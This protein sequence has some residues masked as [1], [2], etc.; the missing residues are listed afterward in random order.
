MNLLSISNLSKIG[1]EEPLFTGV[2]FG[3][4]EG[5]KA[6]L[7]GKNGTGKSTLLNTIAGVL[8]PDEGSIVLNKAGGVSFL[9][10]NPLYQNDDTIREHIFKSDSPKLK[11]INEYQELC[12][13]LGSLNQTQQN[14]YDELM[15][16][17]ESQDL[18]NYES[19]ISSILNTLGITDMSRKMGSLSGGM[20][21]KVAL[22]QVLVEDTKLLLLDEPTNHLDITT[23]KWLQ[24]YLKQTGRALLM[25]THDRYFLDNV[26]TNIYELDHHRLKLYQG[27]YSTYL[28][29]KQTEN[30]IAQ[31]TDRRIESVLRIERDWLM[32]GPCARGTK[33]KARIQRDMELINREKFQE[34]KGF[35]FEVK[36]RRL[37]GKVLE[38]HSISKN[39]PKGYAG[40][41][42]GETTPVIKNFSYNF[43]AGQKIGIFGNNGTGKSTLLNIITGELAPD[44]GSIVVGDNTHFAYYQQ[45]PIFK[46]T[47][48]TVLEYIKEQAE[49]VTMNNGKTYS[50][51][52]FLEEFGFEGKIQYS[53]VSTLSG[54]E[55]KRLFLVRLLISNPNFLI[56]DEPTNDFDIFTMNILE[57]FLTSFEGCLLIVS[58]DRYFMDKVADTLFILEDDGSVSG[59]VGK[60]SEYLDYLEEK[61]KLEEQKIAEQ[62]AKERELSQSASQASQ[63]TADSDNATN[64]ANENSSVNSAPKQKK[65]SFKEQREFEQL[66]KDIDT[67][68]TRKTELESLMSGTDYTKLAEY[69]K[70]YEKVS[71]ELEQKYSR[72][73]ELA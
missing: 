3:L 57:Q 38:L 17:M 70:E 33:A 21:K 69:T 49:N 56:L 9:P 40:A 61:K 60:C 62:K 48:L 25:V 1:R 58:H 52:R 72:W 63:T 12:L 19:Q 44:S 32:R 47:N 10:Q 5:E 36:G 23:I 43:T 18:W 20:I 39:F 50:A 26:C 64:T 34:D 29:K 68:E 27:N 7:I 28:E 41:N 42:A 67:L 15:N 73:E 22:A 31:N 35:T 8:Q 54:G 59:F 55:R 46:N 53:P 45:N 13:K 14:R 30:E 51:A 66:E 11:I 2:T 37:G 24:D 65:L 16:I 71:S 6:A 4:N